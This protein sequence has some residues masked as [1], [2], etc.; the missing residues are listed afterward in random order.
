MLSLMRMIR[1]VIHNTIR[2]MYSR[3]AMYV[4][5]C[6]AVTDREIRACIDDGAN[7]MRDLRREL[8]V[9]TQCG[10]CAREVR[11]ILKEEKSTSA[12]G[13]MGLAA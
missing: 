3:F 7:S 12:M 10:K 2:F 9:G 11:D 5:I 13:D 6:H 1:N 4:C 8:C